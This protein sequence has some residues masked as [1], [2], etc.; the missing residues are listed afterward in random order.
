MSNPI[1][2]LLSKDVLTG[3]NFQKWKSNLNIVLVGENIKYILSV[4]RP[5]LPNNTTARHDKDAYD[6]WVASNNKAIAYML[7]SMSDVLRAKF[8]NNDSAVDILDSLQEMFGQKNE[9]ACIEITGKYTTARMKTGTPVTDHV[10]MM[11]NYFTEAELHRAKIGQVT[12]VGII[13][14]SLS[15]DFIQF[16]SNYIMNKLN[17]SVSQLLN[18]LQTFESIS[19]LGKQMASINI[20]DRPNSS[21]GRTSRKFAKKK[22]GRP[23]KAEN[24]IRKPVFKRNAKV[25]KLKDAKGKCFYCHE[26]GHWKK[27]CSKYLEGLKAKK[28]QGN[29]PL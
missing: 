11:T 17:Y 19:R 6:Q 2:A 15:L 12:Q 14:N 16:N 8:E 18:E 26:L 9:Q 28:D 10:M 5:P 27:N 13:L 1:I 24:K 3:E 25:P 4:P 29:V 23:T 20:A 21:K 22:G 7:A